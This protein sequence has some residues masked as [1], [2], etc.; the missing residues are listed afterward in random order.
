MR[1]RRR[2]NTD[3][4][5]TATQRGLDATAVASVVPVSVVMREMWGWS[6][7]WLGGAICGLGVRPWHRVGGW[8]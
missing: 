2:V 6:M 1:K 3:V 5:F 4:L 8:R 7:W